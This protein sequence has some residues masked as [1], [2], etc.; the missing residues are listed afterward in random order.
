M[1]QAIKVE[2]GTQVGVTSLKKGA[3]LPT[4]LTLSDESS[5]VGGS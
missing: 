5:L 3:I 1:V 2:V 4:L